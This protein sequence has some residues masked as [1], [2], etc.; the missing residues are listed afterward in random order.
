MSEALR[1]GCLAMLDLFCCLID[2]GWD[3]QTQLVYGHTLPLTADL[4]LKGQHNP[5]SWPVL[6]DCLHTR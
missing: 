1:N 4:S 2:M 5:G 3:Q 6:G